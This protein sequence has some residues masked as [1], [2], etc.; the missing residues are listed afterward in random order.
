M[1]GLVLLVGH[2]E[3]GRA[4]RDAEPQLR[5]YVVAD[6]NALGRKTAETCHGDSGDQVGRDSPTALVAASCVGD[7]SPAMSHAW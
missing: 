5:L 2:P 4:C 1:H 7:S 3:L 6:D